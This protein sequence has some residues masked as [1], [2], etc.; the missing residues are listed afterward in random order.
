MSRLTAEGLTVGY[1]DRVVIDGLT[2]EIPDGV[3][4]TIVGPNGCGKSTLLRSISR[5]L[6]PRSGV[7]RLDGDDIAGRRPRDLAQVLGLLPQDPIAPSGLTVTE[8][9]ERG[10]HP[11]QRWYRQSSPDDDAAVA[12]AMALTGVADLADRPVESLS[13]G[14]R[15]RVW[16]A[17]VLAQQTEILLLDEPT[18]FLDLAHAVDVLDLVRTLSAE[19]GKTVVTVLHDLNLAVRYSDHIVVMCDGAVLARGAPADVITPQLLERAFGLRSVVI[20]DPVTDGPLVV[21]LGR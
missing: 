10:R 18:T 2:L 20:R 17:L 5:L 16:I 6:T 1:D 15:R 7:V 4:T 12:E 8:L 9:V 14:Q 19:H 21:P 13:G 11:H 3:V